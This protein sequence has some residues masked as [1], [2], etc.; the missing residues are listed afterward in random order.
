MIEEKIV[1]FPKRSLGQQVYDVQTK[2]AGQ[3]TQT[4]RETTDEMGKEYMR[5]LW[6][7]IEKHKH[8]KGTYYIV[9]M[10]SRDAIIPDAVKVVHVARRTRP[11][12][13]WGLALYRVDN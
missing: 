13:E 7:V 6:S 10:V 3:K 1:A 4:I 9:E 11:L 2:Y 8:L 12:P 5:S